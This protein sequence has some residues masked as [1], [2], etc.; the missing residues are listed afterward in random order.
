MKTLIVED[1]SEERLLLEEQLRALGHEATACATAEEALA[2]C[3]QAAH[4][5]YILD[6][7]L[8]GMDGIEL[9]RRIRA[10]PR[11]GLAMI[12]MLTGQHRAETIRQALEAG[13]DDYLS[14]PVNLE[15]LTVRLT[16]LERRLAQLIR[17][18]QAESA[19]QESLAQIEQAKRE[20]ES[21]VDS[22]AHVVCLL[23][24]QGVIR[25]ANRTIEAWNLGRVEE[26]KGRNVHELLHPQ[27][28]EAACYLKTFLRNAWEE[29]ERGRS[30]EYAIEDR[31]LKRYLHLQVRPI[32]TSA[33]KSQKTDSFAVMVAHDL[34]SHRQIQETLSKQD[35]LLLGVAGAMNYLLITPN[36]DAAVVHALKTL[37]LATAADRVYIYETHPHPETGEPLMSQRFEW[38]RFTTE[39]QISNPNFRNIPYRLGFR[40]WHDVL[41]ANNSICG[42]VRDLPPEEQDMLAAQNIISI[43]I[44]PITIQDRFWGFLGFDDCHAERQWRE[45][46]EMVLCAMAGSIGGA[47][48]RKQIEEQLRQTSA[49]LRAV[50][51]S[52]PDEYFRIAAD[53]NI[54]DYKVAQDADRQLSD[55][56]FIGKWAAGLLPASI[57]RQ[58]EKAIARVRKTKKLLSIEYSLPLPDRKIHAEEVRLIPFLADQVLVVA[59]DLTER[60]HA[61][62]DLRKRCEQLEARLQK[63][64]AESKPGR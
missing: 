1:N 19:L 22:V 17:R 21:T 5:L 47:L 63:C 14:K 41:R 34:T 26:A 36:F 8:P 40:R 57:E 7:G 46:E 6:V 15:T 32:V 64:L 56:T 45:E 39:T 20:W 24:R 38:D 50:F 29:V 52:L 48:A 30:A 59:R 31:K 3:Q 2:G 62:E 12:L 28:A 55:E 49:D 18:K 53:G 35:R 58:L 16:I 23:D 60:K 37:A 13:A 44:A 9:C 54:L 11:G 61:E 25:R 27:C 42:L 10:L 51:Q 4:A 43:L 33:T